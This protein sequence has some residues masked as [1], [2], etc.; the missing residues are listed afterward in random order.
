MRT[1]TH[2]V[3]PEEE[4]R[5]VRSLLKTLAILLPRH[6]PADPDRKRYPGQRRPRPHH[7]GAPGRG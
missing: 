4:G 7:S 6:L 2:I 3:T 5:T 1:L